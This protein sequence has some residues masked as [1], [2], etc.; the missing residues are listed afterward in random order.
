MSEVLSELFSVYS[1]Q[2]ICITEL[3]F[4]PSKG[5]ALSEVIF[6][7]LVPNNLAATL[8][9]SFVLNNLVHTPSVVVIVSLELPFL[10]KT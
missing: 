8:E 2:S 4:K 3:A 9:A 7:L 10:R 5:L 1:I 6:Q